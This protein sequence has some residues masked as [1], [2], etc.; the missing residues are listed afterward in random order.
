MKDTTF[1]NV[2]GLDDTAVNHLTSAKDIALM[3]RALIAHPTILQYSSIWMDTIRDGT[4]GLTNTNRLVRF[5]AGCDGYKTGSTNE[6]RYCMSATA[7]KDGMRLI[8]VVLGAN[9]GQ[10]RFDEARAMLEYGFA[11]YK[12]FAPVAPGDALGMDVSVRMG[13]ADSV[14][15]VSGGGVNLLL[16]RGEEKNITLE[17]A[18]TESVAAPI[19]KGD[20]LGEICVKQGDTVV[21]VVPAVAG[22][23][24]EL[25][26]IVAS[27]LRIRDRFMLRG[28]NTS[29]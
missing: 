2:T 4:F 15:A 13:A 17:A 20:M 6:A 24:V 8:A 16:R 18:L 12:L 23:N 28:L 27:L 14:G 25:P 26:G 3:S 5:Y 11:G 21:A 19:K 29:K 9:A 1:E 7:K 10:T 22:E